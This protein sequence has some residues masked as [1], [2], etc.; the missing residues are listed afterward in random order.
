MPNPGMLCYF[1]LG[2]G[3]DGTPEKRAWIRSLPKRIEGAK[4]E[5]R[6]R[7]KRG[8]EGGEKGFAGTEM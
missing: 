5:E 7:P 6:G 4:T 2:A 8:L 3:E 1:E